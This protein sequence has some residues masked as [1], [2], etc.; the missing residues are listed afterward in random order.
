M[1]AS[2]NIILVLNLNLFDLLVFLVLTSKS[3]TSDHVVLWMC[4]SLLQVFPSNSFA[5]LLC[6]LCLGKVGKTKSWKPDLLTNTLWV[7]VFIEIGRKINNNVTIITLSKSETYF[8]NLRQ[9][10]RNVTHHDGTNITAFIFPL[11]HMKS[12]S[13]SNQQLE[14]DRNLRKKNRWASVIQINAM[15][16]SSFIR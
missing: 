8:I 1:L 12:Y 16:S 10:F 11:K 3:K 7:L 6:P 13:E 14:N 4:T 15:H 9:Y 2:W 5:S